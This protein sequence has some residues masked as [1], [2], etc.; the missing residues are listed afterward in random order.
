MRASA[1]ALCT[2]LLAT[3]AS[4]CKGQLLGP[5]KIEDV[6]NVTVDKGGFNPSHIYAR[7]GRPITLVF[8]RTEEKTCATE[9]VIASE[10]ITRDLPLHTSVPVVF[11][12]SRAGDIHFACAMNMVS[13]TITVVN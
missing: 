4:G 1:I 13:G 12:P 10:H 9:V 8:N 6:V 7:R 11:M 3:A 2:A 5:P